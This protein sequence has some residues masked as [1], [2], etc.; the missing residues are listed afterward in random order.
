[1]PEIVKSETAFPIHSRRLAKPPPCGFQTFL[2]D[3]IALP[4]DE[5]FASSSLTDVG[6]YIPFMVPLQREEQFAHF[7]GNRRDDPLAALAEPNDLLGAPIDVRPFQRP[8]LIAAQPG[9]AGELDQWSIVIPRG[10]D[11]ALLFTLVQFT[12]PLDR[13]G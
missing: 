11:D 6:E 2:G 7:I 8:N 1:M 3:R 10:T 9:H 5:L 12:D 13:L 4:P